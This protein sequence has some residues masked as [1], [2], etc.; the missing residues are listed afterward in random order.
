MDD[1]EEFKAI[2]NDYSLT[3][4]ELEKYVYENKKEKMGR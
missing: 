4:T 1:W 3:L 2:V